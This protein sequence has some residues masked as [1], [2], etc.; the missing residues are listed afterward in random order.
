MISNGRMGSSPI[1]STKR[2]AS[3]DC[4]P[5]LFHNYS[6]TNAALISLLLFN[7]IKDDIA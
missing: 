3:K 1:S 5:F 7:T 4:F 2:E 6:A